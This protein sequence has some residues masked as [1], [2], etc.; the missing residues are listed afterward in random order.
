MLK[1][2]SYAQQIGIEVAL[3]CRRLNG[4]IRG[5]TKPAHAFGK[6]IRIFLDRNRNLI[7]QLVDC[8]EAGATNVP[9]RLFHLR[10]KINRG[11]KI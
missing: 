7:E 3:H 10:M 8:Y 2:V 6:Q 4:A 9:M 1:F 5:A 11:G